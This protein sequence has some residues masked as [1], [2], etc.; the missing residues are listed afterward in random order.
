MSRVLVPSSHG[1]VVRL[2]RRAMRP[3]S[4]IARATLAGL[5]ALAVPGIAAAQS[6]GIKGGLSYGN[7][8][9]SDL[10]AGN[11]GARTGFA[12]GVAVS[13]GGLLGL[14]IEA[15]YTQRGVTSATDTDA[16]ALDYLDVP[17]YLRVTAPTLLPIAP[18]VYAGPYASFELRCRSGSLSCIDTGRAARSFGALVGAGVRIGS[19]RAISLEGRF[20]YGFTDLHLSTVTSSNTYQSRTLLILLGLAL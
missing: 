4:G 1:A 17:L 18:F 20:L 12:A 19:R 3:M 9:N 2:C 11:L 5:L 8:S 13:A 14:G 16:R 6:I 7:V 10:L 15:L